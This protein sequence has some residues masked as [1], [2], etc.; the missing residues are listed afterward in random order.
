MTWHIDEQAEKVVAR[1]AGLTFT[2]HLDSGLFDLA[3][4][5]ETCPALVGACSSVLM[6][7]GAVHSSRTAQARRLQRESTTHRLGPG[8]ALSVVND[9]GDG[10]TLTQ[11]FF[12]PEGTAAVLLDLTLRVGGDAAQT[13][14]ELR[15]VEVGDG[16]GR[17]EVPGGPRGLAFLHNGLQMNFDQVSYR[18]GE[19]RLEDDVIS[20]DWIEEADGRRRFLSRWWNVLRAPA[21]G[22]LLVGFLTQARM[23]S[24]VVLETDTEESAV[25]GLRAAAYADGWELGP[26]ESLAAE[27][28]WLAPGREA[29]TLVEAYLDAV[30]LVMEARR[31]PHVPTGWCSWYYFYNR[32]TEEDVLRNLEQ[33]AQN[34]ARVEYVQI[35]DGFQS[36][37]GDWLIPND[38]FPR[39]MKFLAERIRAR[40][41]KPGLWL[42]PPVLHKD[43]RTYR[44]HPDW[45]LK[46]REG[47]PILVKMW[48]G[49]VYVLDCSHPEVQAH[50]E[51]LARTVVRDWGYEYLKLDAMG[52]ASRYRARFHQPNTT[53]AQNLRL[54]YEAIRRG[55]G[56][57]TFILGCTSPFGPAVGLVDAIRVSN[58]VKAT[59]RGDC[60]VKAAM[61]KSLARNFYHRRLFINDPDCLVVRDTDTELTLDEVRFLVTGIGMTGG[62]LVASDDMTKVPPERRRLL[63]FL[64]PPLGRAARALDLLE[65]TLPM[66]Y[67]L[68]LEARGERWSLLAVM[69]WFDEP[70]ELTLPLAR[71]GL[72]EAHSVVGFEIW[73]EKRPE[74]QGGELRTGPIPAHASRLYVLRPARRVPQVLATDVHLGQG[75]L[76]IEEA[77]F[78]EAA[79]RLRLRLR[80]LAEPEGRYWL[81][82]DGWRAVGVEVSDGSARL[83]PRSDGLVELHIRRESDVEVV[84][85]FEPADRQATWN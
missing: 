77:A 22:A 78:D 37:T 24:D 46:D 2:Y 50:L 5:E 57:D 75:L 23:F 30:G 55:A 43:S 7:S 61:A 21:G 3:A 69:N 47:N 4:E 84:V 45:V 71:L 25:N 10:L 72:D 62:L 81:A 41:F 1:S 68:P 17:L 38:K 60:S 79:G 27:T 65:R 18:L 32:V 80:R 36:A 70:R 59:W 26:G 29:L 83:N 66:L 42:A 35:D 11:R 58:D 6:G 20:Y 63:S 64:T 12:F 48:L 85:T 44:E 51:N 8:T 34:T 49:E 74:I 52:F 31:W 76:D 9:L 14:E 54:C 67:H 40:G 16:A 15:P 73:E 28:L 13:V 56:D 82:A 19:P 53:R 39:G 33:L